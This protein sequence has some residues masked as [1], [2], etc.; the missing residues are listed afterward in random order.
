MYNGQKEGIPL[1]A[2]RILIVYKLMGEQLLP[3]DALTVF[4]F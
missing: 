2:K 1:V 3:E 4:D